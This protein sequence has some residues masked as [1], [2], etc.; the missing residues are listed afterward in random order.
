MSRTWVP[1]VLAVYALFPLTV[2][3]SG[4]GMLAQLAPGQWSI[5]ARGGSSAATALCLANGSA[6]I[7]LRHPGIACRQLV[8]DDTASD[9]TV[10]YSCGAQGSG[11]THIHRESDGLVQV[12]T[13][14]IVNN[15]PFAESIE[16]RREGSLCR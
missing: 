6:L 10:H 13:Q 8:I 9:V 11:Y 14:G 12:D 5:R 7:Q 4:L 1:I 15:R 3:A 16:A 2:G